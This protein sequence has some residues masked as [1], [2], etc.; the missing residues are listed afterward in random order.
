[1]K[2]NLGSPVGLHRECVTHSSASSC[3]QAQLLFSAHG[4]PFC[5]PLGGPLKNSIL[6]SWTDSHKISSGGSERSLES[7]PRTR[8]CQGGRGCVSA[9]GFW[10]GASGSN[11]LLRTTG[12]ALNLWARTN[13]HLP[14]YLS[15][16]LLREYWSK[17]NPQRESASPFYSI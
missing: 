6:Q 11:N 3:L 14:S 16:A 10:A 5:P 1:M 8:T 9:T 7:C 15:R 2:M 4:F 12:L 13:A 17:Y